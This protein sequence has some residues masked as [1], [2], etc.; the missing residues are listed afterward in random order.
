VP[1]LGR[2]QMPNRDI[3]VVGASA[4]GVE[5]LKQLAGGL[6]RDLPAAIF[7]VLHVPSNGTSALA[8]ILNRHGELRADVARDGEA[9]EPSRI[10]VAPADVHLVLRSGRVVYS[11]APRENGFR[12]AVDALFRSAAQIHGPRV[13]RI[14]LSGSGDDG[15]LGLRAIK[16]AGGVAIVQHPADALYAGMP[17]SALEVVDVDYTLP[18]AEIAPMLVALTAGEAPAGPE[19]AETAAMASESLG[20]AGHEA[21]VSPNGKLTGFTCPDCG[22]PLRE[23]SGKN[24]TRYQCLIGHVYSPELLM[25]EKTQ[26]LEQALW[27]AVRALEERKELA[28]RLSRRMRQANCERAAERFDEQGHQSQESA[29]LIRQMLLNGMVS[30]RSIT[31]DEEENDRPLVENEVEG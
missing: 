23:I 5:A 11:G 31:E 14:V 28:S 29:L 22:G 8:H 10:Y 25:L 15:T 4:G 18:V 1:Q 26:S 19:E 27:S 2:N 7:V 3:I 16:E 30:S 21:S 6:P 24:F 20:A 17:Q 9:I 13:I 12:P